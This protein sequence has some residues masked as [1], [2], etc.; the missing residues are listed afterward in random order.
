MDP[1]RA[2]RIL[3]ALREELTELIEYELTDPRVDGVQVADIILSPDRSKARVMV[4][5]PTTEQIAPALQGLASAKGFLRRQV[6]LNLQLRKVPD[7]SFEIAADVPPERT[8]AL[9]KRIRRG[10]PR[11]GQAATTADKNNP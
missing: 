2:Q 1:F 4:T 3:E 9:L 8:Q 7:L 5:L 11:D 6:S 10:R